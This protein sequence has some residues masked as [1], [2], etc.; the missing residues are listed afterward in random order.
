MVTW[1]PQRIS[2]KVTLLG[3]H[4]RRGPASATAWRAASDPAL[5]LKIGACWPTVQLQEAP[6]R[7]L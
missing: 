5:L 6:D 3:H 4:R 7:A 1:S 2:A